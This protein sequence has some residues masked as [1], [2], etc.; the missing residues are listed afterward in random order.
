MKLCDYCLPRFLLFLAVACIFPVIAG[1]QSAALPVPTL[2]SIN[3]NNVVNITNF[4]AVSSTVLT[5]TT[6]IQN[7]ITQAATTNGGCT[8]EIPAGTYLSGPLT[9]KSG[10]NLQIDSGATLQMLPMSK[11]PNANTTFINGS[12]IHNVEISGAGTIDG[13]GAAWWGPPTAGTRPNFIQFSSSS[14]ILIQ[15]VTL[16][17]PPTFHIMIKNK[18]ANITVQRITINTPGSSPNTDGFDISSTNVLIQNCYVSDGDDNV[19]I[20]GSDPA[21]EIMI[22]NCTFGTGHGVSMGSI[23]SGGVSN[24]VVVNCTFN[25]TDNGIRMKSDN[26][27]GGI[28]Q[29]LSYYNIGMTNIVYAPILIYS[30]YSSY[31]NPT[32]AGITPAVAASTT[33]ASVSSTTPVWR[34]I[35]ISNLTATA[36]QPGMIWSRTELPATNITLAKLN[37][38]ASDS[39]SFDLYNVSRLQLVDSKINLPGGT[40]TF[41]LFDAQVVF[42][43]SSA[44]A[45]LVSLDGI[46]TS[47]YGNI[48]AFYNSLVTLSNTNILNTGPLTLGASTF[49]VSN[50]LKLFPSTVLNF[51][52]GTNTTKIVVATNLVLGGTI[53]VTNGGGFTGGTYTLMTYGGNLSSNLLTLGTTPAGYTYS[54]NTNTAGQVNL[55]VV[56]PPPGVPTNLVASPTNLAINLTWSTSTNAASY[57]LKRSTTNGGTY[58]IIVNTAAT[59]YTDTAVTNAVTYFYVVSATNSAGESANSLQASAAPLPSSLSTNINFQ[60]LSGQMQL[61]WPQDHLGWRLQIQTNDLSEGLGANWI[62]VPNSTNVD[63]MNISLSPT[64]GSVFLR[65]VYP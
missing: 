27:R 58:F 39:D 45:S 51:L 10:I 4:G 2:P 32:T 56:P 65:L 37:I 7:A 23:T 21:A 26:D 49:T 46:T 61:S 33:V 24:V 53:N 40:K 50:N 34:N 20:G 41:A 13:Q 5:N 9:L 6:A 36:G 48:M 25:N 57:N 28:V 64:N 47:S 59:N 52:L 3:I 17:N 54:L 29:N 12:S 62:T 35:V 19:E 16:Q 14:N 15:D 42:T 55:I 63:Q 18:N 43:N 60:I 22:T 8:V 11:W 38:T 30:Y 31:G 1:A 44:S